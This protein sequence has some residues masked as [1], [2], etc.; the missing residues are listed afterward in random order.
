MDNCRKMLVSGLQELGLCVDEEKIASLLAFIILLEKWNNFYNLTAIRSREEIVR[1]HILDSLT[2]L[3]WL[4][5]PEIIDIG[6]GAGLPGIPLAI[7]ARDLNFLL[8]DG[9]AKKT[10]FVQQVVLET[11]LKNVTVCHSRVE[12][13][14][15][16][17]LFNTVITRAFSSLQKMFNFSR[18]LLVEKGVFLAMKGRRPEQELQQIELPF[19]VFELKIPGVDVGRCLI[20]IEK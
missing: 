3:P 9:N 5:G 19:S 8:L 16:E 17:S 12:D 1:L 14:Q 10:R 18:H 2:I 6:T 20:K 15:P 13:F 4:Q 11:G 7:V